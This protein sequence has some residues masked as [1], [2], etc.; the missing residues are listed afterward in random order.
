M[1]PK[2]I[3]GHSA[4]WCMRCSLERRHFLR[5]FR[6]HISHLHLI[7]LNNKED[8]P[9]LWFKSHHNWTLFFLSVVRK[10]IAKIYT[11]ESDTEIMKCTLSPRRSCGDFFLWLISISNTKILNSC[12]LT[13]HGLYIICSRNLKEVSLE[14]QDLISKILEP[15]PVKRF[16]L[17]P[18]VYQSLHQRRRS[19]HKSQLEVVLHIPFSCIILHLIFN[20]I[21]GSP[22]T[23]RY[24]AS[25]ALKHPWIT[26]E[27][28]F[29]VH[30]RHMPDVAKSFRD[31]FT[32]KV[33][34]DR[35][36]HMGPHGTLSFFHYCPTY[37]KVILPLLKFADGAILNRLFCSWEYEWY[38]HLQ[39]HVWR[40]FLKESS[41]FRVIPRSEKISV[42][43]FGIFLLRMKQKQFLRRGNGEREFILWGEIVFL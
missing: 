43:H 4:A 23:I 17:F 8:K 41:I 32:R 40:F 31:T 2:A 36:G 25:E 20:F 16:I 34:P 14:A 30:K 19:S 3:C 9:S 39:L 37:Q 24:S 7:C 22:I 26:G 33:Q 15:D 10:T 38:W 27:G 42:G 35:P 18:A 1:G 13:H 5:K 12:K 11:A 21:V 29:D 6:I 28:H